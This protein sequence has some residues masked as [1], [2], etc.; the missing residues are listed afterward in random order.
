MHSSPKDFEGIQWK[1]VSNIAK[2]TQ[3]VGTNLELSSIGADPSSKIPYTK[4]KGLGEI[5]VLEHRPSTPIIR[6]S[7]VF[8]PED[9]F[10]YVCLSDRMLS[11]RTSYRQGSCYQ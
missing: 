5:S 11:F 4:T 1:G 3:S 2:A 6:P 10:F 9:H 7:L 8:G